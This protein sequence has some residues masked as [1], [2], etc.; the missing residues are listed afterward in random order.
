MIEIIFVKK[1]YMSKPNPMANS[2]KQNSTPENH[3]KVS[4]KINEEEENEKE[5]SLFQILLS[6]FVKEPSTIF[7]SEG[8]SLID[9][10]GTLFT[11]YT[12]DGIT[13]ITKGVANRKKKKEKYKKMFNLPSKNEPNDEEF[14]SIINELNE[15]T[16]TLKSFTEEVNDIKITSFTLTWGVKSGNDHVPCLISCNDCKYESTTR[17]KPFSSINTL[18]V[19]FNALEISR[20]PIP[21]KCFINGKGCYSCEKSIIR[22]KILQPKIDKFISQ[23][24]IIDDKHS[25]EKYIQNRLNILCPTLLMTIVPVCSRCYAKYADGNKKLGLKLTRLNSA[26]SREKTSTRSEVSSLSHRTSR[27]QDTSEATTSYRSSTA[28]IPSKTPRRTNIVKNMNS[29]YLRYTQ[30]PQS[31]KARAMYFNHYTRKS[32]SGFTYSQNFSDVSVYRAHRL[33]SSL[34]FQVYPKPC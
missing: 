31:V 13:Y 8:D 5:L 11:I 2:L 28:P 18:I 26:D 14:S 33:Y 1:N 7:Q 21:G 16:N 34:P 3:L 15:F 30:D 20:V 10:S 17:S 19:L 4:D 27:K 22:H 12:E 9:Q 6:T 24:E 32:P 23:F 25:L 29:S